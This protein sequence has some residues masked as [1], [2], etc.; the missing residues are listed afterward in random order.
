MKGQTLGLTTRADARTD[1]AR[2]TGQRNHF[3]KGSSFLSSASVGRKLRSDAF[4]GYLFILPAIIGLLVFVLYPLL[5]SIYFAL[6]RWTGATA[7]VFVGIH[8]FVELFTADPS[9]VASLVATAYFVA[10][11]VPSSIAV[12]LLLA[13]LLNRKLPGI[14]FFR[15]AMYLP[16]VLPSVATLTLWKFIYSP[17]F[18]FAN[19]L[20]RDV[21]LPT[22]L[23]LGSK[24]LAIPSIVL[25]GV[26]AVGGT[27]IIF[28][29]GLQAVPQDLYEAAR[30][31]GAGSWKL[32]AR[33][34]LPM[35]SPIL[36]LEIVL[37]I[38]TAFQAFNQPAVLTQ[39]GPG[40][41][42]DLLMYS[43]WT[44]AFQ[45]G[46]FGYAIAQV[47]VLFLIIMIFTIFTFRFSRMWVYQEDAVA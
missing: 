46:R 7:P 33:I 42:S 26:W 8:N 20:L 10:L 15:T 11:S 44:N 28:L 5:A 41:S 13:L 34:T 3:G 6:T 21:G 23:W 1:P 12:G 27:M 45:N 40:F 9:F 35:I 14:R 25:I 36:F 31:D 19:E 17:S 16:V 4:V 39:G 22:S 24:T 47:W 38:I 18:G 43:I 32:F 2:T 30:L 29:A 37:Q